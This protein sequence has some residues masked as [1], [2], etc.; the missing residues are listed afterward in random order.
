MYLQYKLFAKSQKQSSIKI[1]KFHL[2]N[3]SSTYSIWYTQYVMIFIPGGY[4]T[5]SVCHS[6]LSLGWLYDVLSMSRFLSL[7]AIW[8]TWYFIHFS[9][10][11]WAYMTYSAC[12]NFCP[13]GL[14][15][16]LGTSIIFLSQGPIWHTQYVI[17]FWPT[18]VY[19]AYSECRSFLSHRGLYDVLGKIKILLEFYSN[20]GCTRKQLLS[21][22]EIHRRFVNRLLI[23]HC[24][25]VIWIY[26]QCQP[27]TE[28]KL[29][30]KLK[31]HFYD[32]SK[33]EHVHSFL[34]VRQMKFFHIDTQFW[35]KL[36]D[37]QRT[38]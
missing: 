37:T 27:Y 26:Q 30:Y 23:S 1:I 24:C 35:Y 20:S 19:M 14:Y 11:A 9:L 10:A 31:R 6:F 17:C 8:H 22:P 18:G 2:V 7:R 15:D 21:A 33:N 5:Y 32:L 29:C 13:L 25:E 38:Q 34:H 36:C 3:P 28:V 12:H 4:M 16:I